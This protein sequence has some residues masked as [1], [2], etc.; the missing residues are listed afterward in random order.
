M[1]VFIWK[2]HTIQH[3]GSLSRINLIKLCLF[4]Q[5]LQNEIK[6]S[7]ATH[8]LLAQQFCYIPPCSSRTPP[9][10][11][12]VRKVAYGNKINIH[13]DYEDVLGFLCNFLESWEILKINWAIV[14]QK[15]SNN[16]SFC[17]FFISQSH[18]HLL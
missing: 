10:K 12:H 8:S 9:Y 14:F 13:E 3:I 17:S 5:I 1:A 11:L 4:L 16:I 7:Y 15:Y 2:D 18:F 6:M